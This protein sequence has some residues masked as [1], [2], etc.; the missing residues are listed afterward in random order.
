M[1]DYVNLEIKKKDNQYRIEVIP[2]A[3]GFNLHKCNNFEDFFHHLLFIHYVLASG[4]RVQLD[5]YRNDSHGLDSSLIGD[6]ETFFDMHNQLIEIKDTF[7]KRKK[8]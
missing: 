8:D 5:V 2:E 7:E 4:K 6:L 1:S 3:P